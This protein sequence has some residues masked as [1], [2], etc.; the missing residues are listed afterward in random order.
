V[1][2][3]IT[4]SVPVEA[5]LDELP[6]RLA[7]A[8][9][10]PPR[11]AVFS[12]SARL[13]G[14]STVALPESGPAVYWCRVADGR[15][16]VGVGTAWEAT[17]GEE[18]RFDA[19][20]AERR[21]LLED[22]STA[23]LDG[24]APARAAFLGFGFR[25][26]TEHDG[27]PGA[28]LWVPRVVAE[29]RG[30]SI[31]L[32]FNGRRDED[33]AL[34][35]EEWMGAARALARI[36]QPQA[37]ER[38][39]AD[40]PELP[41]DDAHWRTRVEQ[42]L[43]RIRSGDIDKLV[44]SR[45]VDL[46]VSRPPDLDRVLAW[47]SARYPAGTVFAVRRPEASLVGVSPERLMALEGGL[48]VADALAGSAA[49][50]VDPTD[51]RR[52][53]D[54]LMDDAK[55]RSEHALVV[56]GIVDALEP[57]CAGLVAPQ[58]PSILRL[59]TVQHLATH[60]HGRVRPGVDV[61]ELVRRLHPT[62]AVGGAPKDPALAWLEE[63]GEHDRGWY[64]GGVGWLDDAG[65]DVWVVLRCALLGAGRATLFAGA[66][67]VEGSDPHAELDETA[68]KLNAILEALALG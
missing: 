19:L 24:S 5:F 29:R 41:A 25:P 65:G 40:L 18:E 42:A 43:E 45:R 58:A 38:P 16:K 55:A 9:S 62:P 63:N 30:P 48:V 10:S 64:T 15:L 53:G 22:W 33:P 11:G 54:A 52:L 34:L 51:D 39:V 61:L 1:D 36:P 3:P 37:G 26:G 49:R 31:V 8:L 20:T 28:L 32:H 50:G 23:S 59:P 2:F 57:V 68:W 46:S 56:K 44:I 21:R 4:E 27:L 67:I 6:R 66:G 12:F 35:L 13:P 47:L 7:R 17:S 14:R 60:V